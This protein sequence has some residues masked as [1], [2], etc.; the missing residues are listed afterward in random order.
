M[1]LFMTVLGRE[2]KKLH[3][4]GIRLKVI[5]DTARFSERLQAKIAKAEALTANNQGLTSISPPITV[6]SG[7]SP[8][9]PASWPVPWR[10]ENWLPTR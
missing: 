7:T 8:R 2:V 10:A 6:V 1:E 4:N 5:G 3:S 9:R